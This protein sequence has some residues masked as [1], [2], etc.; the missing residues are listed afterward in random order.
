MRRVSGRVQEGVPR[1]IAPRMERMCHDCHLKHDGKPILSR[2]GRAEVLRC[3]RRLPAA[4]G[5][6]WAQ[7]RGAPGAGNLRAAA[8]APRGVRRPAGQSPV[9]GLRLRATRRAGR[10]TACVQMTFSQKVRRKAP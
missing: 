4:A 7:V 6:L 5:T 1:P 9:A 2:P 10:Q 8:A 3:S